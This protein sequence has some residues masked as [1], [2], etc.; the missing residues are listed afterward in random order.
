MNFFILKKNGTGLKNQMTIML[1]KMWPANRFSK[2]KS[3]NFHFRKNYVTWPLS[4]N[5]LFQRTWVLKQAS[6]QD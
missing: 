1:F 2:A 3:Y 4:T 5:G 6:K